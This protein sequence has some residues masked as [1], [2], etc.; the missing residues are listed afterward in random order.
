[1]PSDSAY[2]LGRMY[3]ILSGLKGETGIR[4]VR[5]LEEALEWVLSESA[6]A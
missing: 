5:A 1:M 6:S 3:E 2:G 4:V